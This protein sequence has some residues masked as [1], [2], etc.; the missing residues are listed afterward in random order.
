[1]APM[2]LGE[3]AGCCGEVARS[4]P[5][6]L[7]IAGGDGT[8]MQVLSGLRRAYDAMPMPLLV[9][10]P[11]GTVNTTVERWVGT[12][13]PWWLLKQFLAGRG[14][15]RCRETLHVELDGVPHVAATLGTGLISH[16]FHE[17][18]RAESR[19]LVRAGEI[20]AKVFFGS[21]VGSAFANR[22]LAPVPGGL[23]IDGRATSFEAFTLLVCSVHKNVGLGLRPTYR[24]ATMPGRI[25]LVATDLAARH[26]G[27]QAWRVFCARGL[28]APRLVDEMVE[29]FSL[30]FDAETSVI[31][32]GER[33]LA[34]RA[35]ARAGEDL[36]V[37]S[38]W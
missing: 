38:P 22:I 37:W 33:L 13:D 15:T 18:G 26:L 14:E 1:L 35:H 10:L 23:S 27:P 31:L 2:G 21:M 6:V 17:Y 32:D 7:V 24:A 34:R 11:F 3:L 25:H 4:R 12:V 29:R 16:F 8:L 28:V 36:L 30:H 19:G 20:F 9:L 5:D